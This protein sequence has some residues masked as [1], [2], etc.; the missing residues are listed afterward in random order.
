MAAL[1]AALTL[2]TKIVAMTHMSNVLG[3]VTDAAEIVR[4]AHAA[5]AEVLFD[6]CQPAFISTSMCRR[7]AAII[8]C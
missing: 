3:T 1:E 4:L 2:K 8:T 7:S 5:G 6:G